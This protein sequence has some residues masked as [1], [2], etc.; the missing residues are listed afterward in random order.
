MDG[1]DA[2]LLETDGSLCIKERGH[3]ALSYSPT[4][5][6]LLK[7][8]EYAVRKSLGNVESAKAGYAGAVQ[9]Y[10]AT[11]L[12]QT[13]SF[14]PPSF[15][16]IVQQST[17]LHAQAV[18]K[19]LA[20]TGYDMAHIDVVGYHGQTLFHRP[21]QKICVIIGDGQSLADQLGTTVVNDFRSTDIA[22]GGQGAPFAPLYHHA[23]A[24]RDKKIPCAIVNCGG[25]ANITLITHENAMDLAAYDTGPGNGLIDRLVRQRTRG[26]ENMDRDG[27]YGQQGKIHENVLKALYAKAIIKEGRNYFAAKPPKSLDIGDMTLI[28]D[29]NALSLPDACATLEAFTADTIIS[30][31]QCVGR[32]PPPLWILVGGGW[33]NPVIRRELEDRLRKKCKEARILTADEI[34]W[35]SQAMEAQIFAYFAVRS[36][37]KKPLSLP[38]T[39]GVPIPL[40]GGKI[41]SNT[42]PSTVSI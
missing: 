30:S 6:I 13:L 8:A 15:E 5:K 31:L 27:R 40:S 7:A 1:I 32:E 28:D 21:S 2:A 10:A 42:S 12:Q 37:Q 17:A 14:T 16:A 24:I 19:L 22:A 29:L 4:F 20:K 25:I 11:E 9:E 36:L 35:R 33:N 34:G 26:M 23:L 41:F 39:T 38:G 18:Q 3:I